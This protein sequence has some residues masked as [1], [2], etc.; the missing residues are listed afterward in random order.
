VIAHEAVLKAMSAPAGK[1]APTP[2]AAWPTD[3]YPGNSK[4]ISANGE[5]I[6]VLHPGAANTDGDS[7]VYFRRSDVV[8]TGDIFFDYKLSGNRYTERWQIHLRSGGIKSHH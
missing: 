8:V 4:E 6:E 7:I 3:A 1:T 5:G 2:S